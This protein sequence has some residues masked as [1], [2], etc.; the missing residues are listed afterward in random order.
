M[1]TRTSHGQNFQDST[2]ERLRDRGSSATL[3]LNNRMALHGRILDFDPYVL[4]FQPVDGSPLQMIY[5]SAVV[6]V[7]GPPRRRPP[8]GRPGDRPPYRGPR[9]DDGEGRGGYQ[10]S[11]GGYRGDRPPYR[12]EGGDRPPYRGEGGDRPPYRGGGG[13]RPP[14]RSDA[15]PGPRPYGDRE[16]GAPRY[17]GSQEGGWQRGDAP[18]PERREYTQGDNGQGSTRDPRPEPPRESGSARP[19]DSTTE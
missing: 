9:R 15:R 11:E 4:L 14:Y 17:G 7:A 1:Q 13:D 5:K 12:G 6:S 2:L 3:Y 19:D 8:M 10:R 18:A 16:G